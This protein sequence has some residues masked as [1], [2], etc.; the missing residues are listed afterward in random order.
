[1]SVGEAICARF[2][3]PFAVKGLQVRLQAEVGFALCPAPGIKSARQVID[4]SE[5]A[6]YCA[7]H[8]GDR[9]PQL[10]GEAMDEWRA[11]R[12]ELERDLTGALE[13][14]E[15]VVFY[16][17]R[18]LTKTRE[19]VGMEALIRW[20]HPK[21]GLVSPMQ[22]IPIAEQNGLIEAIGEFVIRTSLTQLRTWDAE[23]YRE[24]RV[25]VNL[26]TAQF[27]NSTLFDTIVSSVRESGVAPHRLELELTEGIL[28]RDPKAAIQTL[29]Q[30]RSAGVHVSVDDFGTGY[31]SLSY[32]RRFPVD[33][34]KIDQSFIRQV[35]NNPQDAAITTAIIVLGRSLN[36]T[37]VAE[38]VETESQLAFLKVLECDEVQGYLFGRPAEPAEAVV[39]V[40]KK[41]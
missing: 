38:G 34:M 37:V 28:M 32:L 41:S 33:A 17:P 19:I 1:M 23:G 20:K 14:G 26:S 39:P 40:V 29:Q 16:Q 11:Q 36:L 15:L 3:Q 27:R 10:F 8:L 30:L 6:M 35:T 12:E 2:S 7:A 22:F 24:L 21:H 9:M 13:R 4:R 18:V 25:G 31:S 5:T